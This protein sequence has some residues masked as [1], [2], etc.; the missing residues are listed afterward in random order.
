[1]S[2]KVTGKKTYAWPWQASKDMSR[3]IREAIKKFNDLQTKNT[4]LGANDTE[5]DYH[6]Q[7]FI[8]DAVNE[9]DISYRKFGYNHFELFYD[10]FKQ[11]CFDLNT[12]MLVQARKV[13]DT[14][15]EHATE[16]DLELLVTYCWRIVK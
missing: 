1:M 10:D 3:R 7:V 6:F 16:Q 8:M 2:G 13:Y 12:K 5:P 4:K 15:I 9:N 11:E 14:I